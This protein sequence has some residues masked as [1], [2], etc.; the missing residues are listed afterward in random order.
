MA[1]FD[2]SDAECAIIAPLLPHKPCGASRADDREVLNG[3][4]NSGRTGSPWRDLPTR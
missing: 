2:L 1:R 4:V 3:S